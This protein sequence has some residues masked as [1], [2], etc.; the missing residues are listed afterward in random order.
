MRP[1]T[2]RMRWVRRA[3]R[4]RWGRSQLRLRLRP[5]SRP[6]LRLRLRLRLLLRLLRGLWRRRRVI[7]CWRGWGVLIPGWCCRTRTVCSWRLSLL[8]F[9]PGGRAGRV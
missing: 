5:R 7:R 3:R 9:W 4:V 1:T 6:R 2:R 8:S